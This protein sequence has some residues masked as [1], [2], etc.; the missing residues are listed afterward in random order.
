MNKIKLFIVSISLVIASGMASAAS[1]SANATIQSDYTWRGMS[2]NSGDPSINGGIDLEFDSGFYAGYWQASIAGGSEND[3]YAGF[4]GS[5]GEVGFDVGYVLFDYPAYQNKSW[6]FEELYLGLDLPMGVGLSF[7]FG[8]DENLDPGTLYG[9]G[10][11]DNI[12]ISYGF[13]L[14]EGSL[15]LSYGEYDNV[16]DYYYITYGFDILDFSV[17]LGYTDF[18]YDVNDGA[19][20]G[21]DDDAFFIDIGIL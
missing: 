10:I 15:G 6:D 13:D 18:S 17:T 8:M 12:E 3:Y 5:L 16:G 4:A 19:S 21:A 1:V 7:A 9:L 2:Q 20:L 14:G 11:D